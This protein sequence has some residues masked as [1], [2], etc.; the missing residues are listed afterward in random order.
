MEANMIV[1]AA[2]FGIVL[3]ALHKVGKLPKLAKAKRPPLTKVL[4]WTAIAAA[5]GLVVAVL[6]AIGP[7]L[8]AAGAIFV[9]FWICA[10]CSPSTRRR[11]QVV[12]IED[13]RNPL[14]RLQ[15]RLRG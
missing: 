5:V 6:I 2:T 3:Y 9:F 13:N 4:K 15:D 12:I 11:R 8:L 14:E 10:A 1:G 7:Y